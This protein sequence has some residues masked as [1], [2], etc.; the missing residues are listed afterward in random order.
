MKTN[1]FISTLRAAPCNQ[2]IFA[3]LD[4]H[5][6]HSVAVKIGK[7]QLVTRRSAQCGDEFVRFHLVFCSFR[8]SSTNSAANFV[9]S[10]S[11]AIY[12][13]VFRHPLAQSG[14]HMAY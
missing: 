7:D 14:Q 1:E 10:A 5:A 3:D 8:F 2:L 4:G 13:V 9:A 12:A 11:L 6:V